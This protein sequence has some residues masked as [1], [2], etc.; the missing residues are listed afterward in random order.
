MASKTGFNI[1]GTRVLPVS[2]S[3]FEKLKVLLP[4]MRFCAG[5]T[6][7]RRAQA[8]ASYVVIGF[9][10]GATG[11]YFLEHG[12]HQSVA[13]FLSITGVLA[14]A[15]ISAVL[16]YG[17]LDRARRART[18]NNAAQIRARWDYRPRHVVQRYVAP[19]SG[20]TETL[21]DLSRNG[22]SATVDRDTWFNFGSVDS[23]AQDQPTNSLP[24]SPTTK[25]P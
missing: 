17:K 11:T 6:R 20:G 21:D 25:V 2:L 18:R 22:S 4:K 1:C 15:A 9:F 10:A 24:Q 23:A 8:I 16:K 7:T 3:S 12:F 14:A 19:A 13:A 5:R